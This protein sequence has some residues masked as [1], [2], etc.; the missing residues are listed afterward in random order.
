ML[1]SIAILLL[2]ASCF[3]PQL[4]ADVGVGAKP[5]DGAEV[6]IDGSRKM[7]DAKWTYWEGPRFSSS[8]PIKWKIVEDPVDM[9]Q[10]S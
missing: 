10:S 4:I 7:L 8:L 2:T 5:V 9:E 6:I 1:R 3:S